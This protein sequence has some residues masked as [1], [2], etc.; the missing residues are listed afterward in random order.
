MKLWKLLA[1]IPLF[2]C[3]AEPL[4]KAEQSSQ[5]EAPPVGQTPGERGGQGSKPIDGKMGNP[6]I[7]NT[8]QGNSDPNL[9]AT[10]PSQGGGQMQQIDPNNP[11]VFA[12]LIENEQSV[13]INVKVTNSETFS[14]EFMYLEDKDDRKQPNLVH[15]QISDSAELTIEAPKNYQNELWVEIRSGTSGQPSEDDLSAGST[16]AIKLGEEDLNLEFTLSKGEKWKEAW[17]WFS[18]EAP[19]PEN[20]PK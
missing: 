6:E 17:D 11:P 4:N 14:I 5:D 19:K 16:E 13:M 10:P 1:F 9:S 20:P 12:D 2:G 7:P 18:K 8:T 15:R 3:P